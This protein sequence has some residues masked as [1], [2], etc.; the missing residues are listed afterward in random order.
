MKQQGITEGKWTIG[1]GFNVVAGNAGPSPEAARPSMILSV[2][3]I[4][5]ALADENTPVS[6]VV[7]AKTLS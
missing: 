2:D 3:K 1:L 5:L 7:D 6:M 4:N